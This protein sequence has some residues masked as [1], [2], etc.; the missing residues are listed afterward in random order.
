[1]SYPVVLFFRY[2]SYA[3]ADE[4]VANLKCNVCIT[5]EPAD[6]ERLYSTDVHLLVTYGPTETEY[7]ADVHRSICQRLRKRWIHYTDIDPATFE[8]GVNYCFIDNVIKNRTDTRPLF[9]A[10]TTCFH[11]FEKIDRP[12]KS[13][14][15]QTEKDWE[16]VILDDSKDEDNWN[17]MKK[18]FAEEPKIRLY[19]RAA[20]SG[21]IGNVKNEAIGLCRGKYIL[22]LDHDDEI[23]PDLIRDAVDGF[24]RFPDVDFI[25]MDFINL[26][27][28]GRN[29]SYGDFLSKGYGG[30]YYQYDATRKQWVNVY[31]TPQINNI[32]A[33]Y[34]FCLPNHP[35]IW[36]REKLLEIG[37]YSEFLPI[38]DDQEVLLRTIL[39]LQILKIPK[40]SY[41]QYFNHAGS[42]F[43]LIR[44][45][46]INRL[47]PR[48][49]TPQFKAK[50]PLDQKMID[51]WHD[52]KLDRMPVQIWMQTEYCPR[53]LNQLYHPDYDRQYG[54]IGI[55]QL[56]NNMDEIKTLYQ[57]PRNDFL[58]LENSG[59][60]QDLF[61][62][63]M[64][65]GL[66]R[67]KCYLLKGTPVPNL[68]H[69]FERLYRSTAES[70][71][72]SPS[73]SLSA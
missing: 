29:F 1:M 55:D 14:L 8:R 64:E 70:G 45:S 47:G 48:F 20:N 11:S 61:R 54:I 39:S 50:Y 22:E 28:D 34:L 66:S 40:H 16:W 53:F 5:S 73:A 21:N 69:Y 71:L 36:R 27:E 41:V 12:Y 30:Y 38:C 62:I 46:E 63:L 32:T 6:L 57:N 67:I 7:Y 35:R 18:K 23:L 49:I 59:E 33:S 25:Y 2:D 24:T 17:Y 31:V 3:D 42:N 26:Y 65:H 13:L 68:I 58:L 37:S 72:F 9:S 19:R 15:A 56:R 10:F 44:N 52:P 51:V 43:S 4:K 60:V